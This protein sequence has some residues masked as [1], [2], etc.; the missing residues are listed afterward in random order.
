[1]DEK[2]A[3]LIWSVWAVSVMLMI[4]KMIKKEYSRGKHLYHLIWN[5]VYN[6]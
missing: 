5:T 2:A 1:M 6:F 3:D 4:K